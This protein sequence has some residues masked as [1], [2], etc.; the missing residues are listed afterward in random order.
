[1]LSFV[2]NTINNEFIMDEFNANFFFVNIKIQIDFEI[3]TIFLTERRLS[4]ENVNLNMK[5]NS[6][7]KLYSWF[8]ETN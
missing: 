6:M 5:L 3:F 1:M 4:I 2:F 7:N 8:A